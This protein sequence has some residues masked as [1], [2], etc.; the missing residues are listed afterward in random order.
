MR[1]ED[2]NGNWIEFNENFASNHA[3]KY[4]THGIWAKPIFP[5]AINLQGSIPTPYIFDDRVDIRDIAKAMM[6]WYEAGPSERRDCGMAGYEWVTGNEA[7]MTAKAMTNSFIE[8]CD[9]VLDNWQPIKR[10]KLYNAQDNFESKR[11]KLTG[12]ELSYE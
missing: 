5:A 7:K 2:E 4:K 11:K 3:G 12:I 8:A 9:N 10:F 6:Y 1:F